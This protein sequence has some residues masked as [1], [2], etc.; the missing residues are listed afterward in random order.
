MIRLYKYTIKLINLY[1]SKGSK[2]KK[3]LLG[4]VTFLFISA[5]AFAGVNIGISG[6]FTSL[7]TD[8]TETT[9]SSK[10]KNKGSKDEDVTVPS[11][12]IEFTNDNGVALGIDIVPGEAELGN[13]T[14]SNDDN[15]ST[16]ANKASA[17]LESHNTIYAL[18]PV[19]GSGLYVKGGLAMATVATTETL[20]TGTTYGN[21]DVDG[22]M[23]G[24]G[25]Q[26]ST[27]GGMFFRAEAT[28]TDYDDVTFNGSLDS[29]NVRNVV[30]A[31]IDAT[32]FRI[33]LGKS[34]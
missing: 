7:E 29:D 1:I 11:L 8:G 10:E 15:E 2:M 19:G 14:G 6:A 18:V 32:A 12:F 9:K 26:R 20:K 30:D 17:E 3:I 28:Y 33:S 24:L 13:G 31:D 25:L 4:I 16:G 34:F 23:I 5:N 21:E 22:L 27:A